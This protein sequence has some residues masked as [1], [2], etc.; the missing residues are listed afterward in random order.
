M[1][2]QTDTE[3]HICRETDRHTQT[4]KKTYIHRDRQTDR[5]KDIQMD[6]R[7]SYKVQ[8]RKEKKG[9]IA[10]VAFKRV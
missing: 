10:F 2:I 1:Y 9:M 8:D 4:D 7:I 5:Q 3:I 6:I